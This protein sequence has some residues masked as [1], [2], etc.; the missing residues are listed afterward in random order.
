MWETS[1]T[2]VAALLLGGAVAGFVGWFVRQA[3]VREVPQAPLTVPWL[4][5]AGIV[6][7]CAVVLVAAAVAGARTVARE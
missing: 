5:L 3:V 6:A 1:F 7:A 4:P 2:G